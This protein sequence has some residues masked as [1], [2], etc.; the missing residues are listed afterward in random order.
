MP[1]Y[2][3][4]W[5]DLSA[6]LVRARNEADLI[7]TLDQVGNPDGCEWSRYE[8]PLFIDVRLPAAWGLI[9]GMKRLATTRGGMMPHNQ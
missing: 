3:V 5:P 7:D 4:R 2:L 8:G 9:D 6:S 1:I